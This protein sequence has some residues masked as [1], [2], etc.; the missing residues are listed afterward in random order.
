VL[1]GDEL[2]HYTHLTGN[3][4]M[5]PRG[6][7][8]PGAMDDNGNGLFRGRFGTPAAGHTAGE[9][10]ILFNFRYWDRWAD[11][12]DA[13]ELS[14]FGLSI[15]QPNA[16]WR[17]VF[18][19]AEEPAGTKLE[20]LQRSNPLTPWDA[21]PEAGLGQDL[22]LLQEGLKDG[23]SRPIGVQRDGLEWRIYVRY[24]PNAF[25]AAQGLS[26]GWKRTPRLTLF[27]IEYLGPSLTLRRVDE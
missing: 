23:A 2:I 19:K 7:S 21:E 18:F 24:A 16:F 12:A 1:I 9:P 27:G 17:G 6:S 4:L 15:D 26:H 22:S 5:M 11:R 20:V 10:V 8:V 14:Y 3:Q 25:D 13:P